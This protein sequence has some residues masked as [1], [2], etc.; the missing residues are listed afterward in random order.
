MKKEQ[1]ILQLAFVV[2]ITI[3]VFSY[4]AQIQEYSSLGYLGVFLI[5]LFSSATIFLPAPGWIVVVELGRL[6]DPL[7]LGVSA[8]VGSAFGELTGYFAGSGTIALLKLKS[9]KL[10]KK[11]KEWIKKNNFLAILLLS[12]IP[13]PLFDFAGLYAGGSGMDIKK[14]LLACAIG[15][16]LRFFL[17]AYLG[18]LSL[19]FL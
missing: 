5:S 15:K 12:F 9:N 4:G 18:W 19:D 17:L 3:F 2:I 13:N 1:A 6:L 10:F 14:F 8:G 11:H 16:S 7:L